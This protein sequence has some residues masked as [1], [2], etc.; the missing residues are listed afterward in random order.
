MIEGLCIDSDD[1]GVE[2]PVQDT[3][4]VM[5]FHTAVNLIDVSAAFQFCRLCGAKWMPPSDEERTGDLDIGDC[6]WRGIGLGSSILFGLPNL[7]GRG[8]NR[9]EIP[10]PFLGSRTDSNAFQWLLP[11]KDDPLRPP[12]PIVVKSLPVPLTSCDSISALL[13]LLPA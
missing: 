10:S 6:N 9:N 5:E 12:E 1:D 4:M 7:L 13:S 2:D 3:R 11:L 8:K